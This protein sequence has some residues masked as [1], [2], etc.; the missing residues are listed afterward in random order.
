MLISPRR[1]WACIGAGTVV[2]AGLF[3]AY[4]ALRAFQLEPEPTIFKGIIGVG[5]LAACSASIAIW[6]AWRDDR[7]ILQELSSHVA[8][9]RQDASLE[10][11]RSL[12]AEYGPLYDELDSLG[13]SYRRALASLVQQTDA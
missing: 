3:T 7:R 2:A 1:A 6:I 10:T 9:L 8:A 11:I 4:L 13:K 12:P 5:F